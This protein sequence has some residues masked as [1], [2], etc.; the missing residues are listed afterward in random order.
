MEM[1]RQQGGSAQT[2]MVWDPMVRLF[3]WSLVILFVTALLSG[4]S[5]IEGIHVPVGYLLSALLLLRIVWGVMG[6][7]YAQFSS[8]L[9]GP[10]E[11]LGYLKQIVAGHPRRYLGHNPAGAAMV[12]LLLTLLLMT[13][14]TGLM[15]AATIEFEGP[16]TG[17]LFNV[18]DQFA[19]TVRHLHEWC[20]NLLLP[21]IGA[22]LL[23]V[24]L[25]SRQ[26]HENLLLAMI[27]GKK[28]VE[29]NPE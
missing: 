1:S 15:V 11:T 16:F 10:T 26:H 3:H 27:T 2:V 23:G 24:F 22:H 28:K 18:S 8:F 29:G 25:A 14:V 7:R 21:C 17:M 20:V 6:T 9:F 5:G 4:E 13:L 19:Q 12:F